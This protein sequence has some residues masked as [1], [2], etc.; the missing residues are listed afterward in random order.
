SAFALVED[1]WG[2][3]AGDV[4]IWGAT[5]MNPYGHVAIVVKV[6]ANGRLAVFEQDGFKQDGAK[7]AWRDNK[8]LI[9]LLRRWSE[10]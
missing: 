7:L 8:N 3:R 5:K 2:A 9:G 4:A 10:I 6:R 1:R